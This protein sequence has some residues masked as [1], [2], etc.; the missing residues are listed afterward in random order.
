M[1]AGLFKQNTTINLPRV[2]KEMFHFT[3]LPHPLPD[4]SRWPFPSVMS[5][6]YP[7]LKLRS[8]V[9]NLIYASSFM[10][11]QSIW[12]FE[13]ENLPT[14]HGSTI[15]GSNIK[16]PQWERADRS[17]GVGERCDCSGFGCLVVKKNYFYIGNQYSD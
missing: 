7:A 10:Y 15:I 17:R 9:C 11:S 3:S 1:S 14:T 12:H 4:G 6:I 13:W 16:N 5:Y 8:H 2:Y